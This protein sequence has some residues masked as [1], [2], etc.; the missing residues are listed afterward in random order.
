MKYEK[1]DDNENNSE[2]CNN[3][4]ADR[5]EKVGRKTHFAKVQPEGIR[6]MRSR[7]EIE[8]RAEK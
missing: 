3:V 1:V 8:K 2:N 4:K 6:G 7:N 5:S